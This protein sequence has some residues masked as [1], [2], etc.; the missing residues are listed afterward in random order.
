MPVAPTPEIVNVINASPGATGVKETFPSFFPSIEA[1][2]A[3]VAVHGAVAMIT[4]AA[5]AANCQP[6]A[7]P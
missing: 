5:V 6:V 2:V 3:S 7:T 4:P 1:F